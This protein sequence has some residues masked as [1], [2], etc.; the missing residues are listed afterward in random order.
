MAQKIYESLGGTE[1]CVALQ[2][3]TFD[4]EL[5]GLCIKAMVEMTEE[6]YRTLSLLEVETKKFLGTWAQV[7]ARV[8]G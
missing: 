7:R 5:L 8:G 2:C 1:G 4:E 3:Y 6:T